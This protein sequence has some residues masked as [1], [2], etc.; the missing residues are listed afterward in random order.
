VD[1]LNGNAARD[2]PVSAAVLI[3]LRGINMNAQALKDAAR[4]WIYGRFDEG[5]FDIIGEM[6][7]EN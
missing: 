3:P 2:F 5:N 7:S 1:Y 6:A 4:R